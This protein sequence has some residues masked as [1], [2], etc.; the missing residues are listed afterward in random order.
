MATVNIIQDEQQNF[1][2]MCVSI[3]IRVITMFCWFI[4]QEYSDNGQWNRIACSKSTV[5][6]VFC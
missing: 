3:L 6:K 2:D 4:Q 1:E 5:N